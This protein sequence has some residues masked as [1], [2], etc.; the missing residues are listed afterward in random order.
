[1]SDVEIVPTREDYV[2]LTM[3]NGATFRVRQ[4]AS[5]MVLDEN[6]VAVDLELA[7]DLLT[8]KAWKLSIAVAAGRA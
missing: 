1:M 3:P 6:G 2:S 4:E 7:A 8:I 5:G